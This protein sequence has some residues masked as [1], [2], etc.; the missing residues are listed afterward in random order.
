MKRFS[1]LICLVFV[2]AALSFAGNWQD[3]N[4][5]LAQAVKLKKPLLIDFYTDWCHWCKVMDEKTF[6]NAE[7]KAYLEAHFVTARLHAEDKSAEVSF[8]GKTY[9]NVEF[10]R[11][12][13]IRGFPSLVFLDKTGDP[14]TV[15]PGFVP[16][17]QFLPILK[18]IKLE[19]YQ[20]Q[21]SFEDFLKK[22][23]EC[24]KKAAKK[25]S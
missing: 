11:A 15:I 20:Q 14:I 2:F 21:M 12:M 13:G 6:G 7:V 5:G 22:Q 23:E 18:Y 10:T 17:E 19:C 25:D 3:F 16:P 1:L 4:K 9:T 24:E 8:R